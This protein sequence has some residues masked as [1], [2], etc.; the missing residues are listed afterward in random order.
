[1]CLYWFFYLLNTS[2]RQSAV[3]K[4]VDRKL[5]FVQQTYNIILMNERK[6]QPSPENASEDG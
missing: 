6:D 4:T 2:S 3:D 5:L 1:M